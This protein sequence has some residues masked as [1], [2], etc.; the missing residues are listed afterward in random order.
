[1]TEMTN[2]ERLRIIDR[3]KLTE[4]VMA[5]GYQWVVTNT[6]DILVDMARKKLEEGKKMY[7]ELTPEQKDM[8]V[9]SSL[10]E[11]MVSLAEGPEDDDTWDMVMNLYCALQY[12]VTEDVMDE[13]MNEHPEVAEICEW[14]IQ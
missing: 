2:E 14:E 8:A 3:G 12:Y 11:F 4:M 7:I 13:F 6:T 1:M 9:V 5:H 10:Q